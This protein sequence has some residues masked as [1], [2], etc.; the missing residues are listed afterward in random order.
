MGSLQQRCIAGN[1]EFTQYFLHR[2]TSLSRLLFIKHSDITGGAFSAYGSCFFI[3]VFIASITCSRCTLFT[4][5]QH[6]L[7]VILSALN[8]TVFLLIDLGY[9]KHLA[10]TTVSRV[11]QKTPDTS[12]PP[13]LYFICVGSVFFLC[14][15]DGF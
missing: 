7:R 12:N 5:A 1:R 3:K 8:W 2:R 4:A 6:L 10:S 11:R 15:F 9:Q 13:V 14:L